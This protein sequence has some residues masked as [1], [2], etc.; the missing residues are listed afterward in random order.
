MTTPFIGQIAMFAGNFAPKNTAFC[1][2]QLLPINQNQA[3]FSLLGTSYGGN[4]I[5]NFALPNLQSRLPVHQG[6]GPGLSPYILG[7]S[8][9]A[10]N[11]TIDQTTMPSHSHSF[12]ATTA[13]ATTGTIASNQIPAAPT[14]ANAS[15]YAVS[16]SLPNPPLTPQ[17]LAAGTCGNAG[18]SQP[19]SNLMPT[20]CVSFLI[21]LTGVFP[22]RN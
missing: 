15:L 5:N 20:L 11:V 12:Y 4:G 6:Q 2:G 9:G 14:A 18:G 16:A 10:E 7:Q 3:L 8:A 19:H 13:S 21:C 22:S 1:N 17:A